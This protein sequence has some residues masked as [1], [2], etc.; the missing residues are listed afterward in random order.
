MR[1][2]TRNFSRWMLVAVA[3]IGAAGSFLE[4]GE[5]A[6]ASPV[7]KLQEFTL[8]Q[9]QIKDA[10][11][12]NLFSKD[13]GYLTTTIDV[14][15]LLAPFKAVSA[16]QDPSTA[17]GLNLYGGWEAA[18]S[19]LRGHTMGH[20]LS[21]LAH[22]Y[23]QTKGSDPVLA[24]Q[25]QA[26]IDYIITQLKSF[27]DKS[28]NGYLFG[29]PE[30]QFDI[31]EGKAAGV[32]W[33][34]WYTMH[35]VLSG[36]VDVYEFEGNATALQIASKL[37]DWTYTRA[38]GWS[39]ATRTKVLGIEYGGMNDCL[40]ELYKL[41]SSAKHLAA[42]HVFDETTLFTPVSQSTDVL[43]GLH[44][45]T[46]IPKFLGALNR[47]R[48][49]GAAEASYF[50]AAD[51]FWNL[52]L[53]NHTFV[54]G[55]HGQDEHFHVPGKLDAIRDNVTNESCNAYNMEKLAR[56]LFK[57]TGNVKYA[58]YY[59]R[60]HINE[61]LSAMNPVTGMTTY[62]K[63]MGTGYF[64]AYGT[65]DSTFWCCNGT[66]MENYMKLNDSLYFH[67]AADLYVIGY[68]SSTLNWQER[69][70]SLEQVADVALTHHASFNIKGA[71]TA[72]VNLK[73]RKPHGS[74]PVRV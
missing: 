16:G 20:Y 9:V 39:A 27:Q 17:P 62:F 32:T 52:V 13:A 6:A 56:E 59:E 58:D 35:K 12:Q 51:E 47:Y 24:G 40:Y 54:T 18:S 3:G 74:R 53:K 44:A 25:I 15:R 65:P 31:V 67:D 26:K 21:A 45:N 10:Y 68:V 64:K 63:P 41:T 34:P 70:L 30:T 7:E 57:I 42:A 50:T 73:F 49:L 38:S 55:G 43:N 1:G 71:P 11:Y 5:A 28:P 60:T 2:T 69:G 29:S 36:L 72:P 8:D 33:V 46:T 37:G 22:G 19:L 4:P 14:D 48:V 23:Q 66:G 61:V